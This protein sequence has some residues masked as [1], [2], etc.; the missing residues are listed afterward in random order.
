MSFRDRV[1]PGRDVL[2]EL[3][4]AL[5]LVGLLVAAFLIGSIIGAEAIATG[6]PTFPPRL[7]PGLAWGGAATDKFLTVYRGATMV[8]WLCAAGVVGAAGL[9]ALM[10]R[11]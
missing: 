11:E 7:L 3:P 8:L 5:G 9:S 10:H 2:A 1:D 6:E 4:L